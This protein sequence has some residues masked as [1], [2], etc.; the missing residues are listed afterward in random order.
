MNSK[1]PNTPS[2]DDVTFEKMAH[3]LGRGRKKFA[4]TPPPPPLMGLEKFSKEITFFFF[5]FQKIYGK[6]EGIICGKYEEICRKYEEIMSKIWR[7]IKKYVDILDSA[8]PLCRLW[9][10]EKFRAFSLY[11]WPETWK[12]SELSPHVGSGTWKISGPSFVLQIH[13]LAKHR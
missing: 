8:P 6:Y 13:L 7:N 3:Y 9:D 4:N 5:C 11:K 12:N 2:L 10:L 1:F